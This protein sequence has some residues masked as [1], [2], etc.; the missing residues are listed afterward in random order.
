SIQMSQLQ[1]LTT[2]DGLGRTQ[3]TTNSL[4]ERQTNEYDALAQLVFK[5]YPFSIDSTG[6]PVVPLVGDK[7]DYDVMGRQ[8]AVTRRY[9][10]NYTSGS[11]SSTGGRCA[12]MNSSNTGTPTCVTAISYDDSLH[13]RTETVNRDSTTSP[14]TKYCYESFGNPDKARL[15]SVNDAAQ[16]PWKFEYDISGNLKT[17]TAPLSAGNRSFSYFDK[18]FWLNTDT[19]G[20]RATTTIDSYDAVGNPCAKTDAR[21]ITASFSYDDPLSR[22][23]AATYTKG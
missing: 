7:F 4:L 9:L 19:S 13:C 16:K 17:F 22:L 6:A 2:F 12:D 18:Y 14:T 3:A 21:G 23:T 1:E 8:K 15:V 20:P 10:P 5:S 11:Y